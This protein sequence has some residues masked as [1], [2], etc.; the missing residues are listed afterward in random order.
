MF[1]KKADGSIIDEQGNAVTNIVLNTDG[2]YTDSEGK[3]VEVQT[4]ASA[5]PTIADLQNELIEVKRQ[6]TLLKGKAQDFDVLMQD[7]EFAQWA[8]DRSQRDLSNKP[9]QQVQQSINQ[10]QPN[11]NPFA[12]YQDAEG[13]QTLTNT[14]TQ[15]VL[16]AISPRFEAID[17]TIGQKF[18]PL[19]QNLS[20][21]RIEADFNAL[22]QQAATNKE[23]YPID[24][25]SI[26]K[27]IDYE[28]QK[29]P[30]LNMQQA[31]DL[32]CATM[33]REG[34]IT[35]PPIQTMGSGSQEGGQGGNILTRPA[36]G[37][38]TI[39]ADAG[40]STLDKA[41]DAKNKGGDENQRRSVNDIIA[42]AA[43]QMED[44]GN[45][46]DISELS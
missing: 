2:S 40:K 16:D 32:T 23:F 31:Y 39:K 25:T 10:Q 5:Q 20:Q 36:G 35:R 4:E 24:P 21:N 3:V 30:N 13:L 19:L 43:K 45:P 14:I 9:T 37:Q 22:V 33:N 15:N 34:L 11:D 28:R 29:N 46:I 26:R 41:L 17:K 38:T 7:R 18:E 27:Q 42:E 44:S 12:E 1:Y 6:N 8:L